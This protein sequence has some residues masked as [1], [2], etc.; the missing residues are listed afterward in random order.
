MSSMHPAHKLLGQRIVQSQLGADAGN[1]GSRS[2][3]TR[4]GRYRV[5]RRQMEHQ[6][7]NQRDDQCDWN[8]GQEPS[9]NEHVWSP[10]LF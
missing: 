8:E 4:D 5:A 9:K 6:E 3:I 10:I 2:G 1:V 7:N